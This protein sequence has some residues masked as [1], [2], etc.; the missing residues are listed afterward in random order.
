MKL[1]KIDEK[2][3]CIPPLISTR[4]QFIHAIYMKGNNLVI[5]LL[6][7][8]TIQIPNL[9]PDVIDKIFHYYTLYLEKEP[10]VA[11]PQDKTKEI[12]FLQA[13]EGGEGNP[14]RFSINGID[15]MMGSAMMHN[16]EQANAPDLP[17]EILDKIA[18]ITKILSPNSSEHLPKPEPHCNCMYCQITKTILKSYG[19]EPQEEKTTR[20][21]ENVSQEDL[22]FEQWDVKQT[23]DQLFKV[24]NRLDDKEHYN[25]YLGS[26]VGC[27]CGKANCEHIIAVLKS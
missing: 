15:G 22:K 16:P 3:L 25:V 7:Y 13:L 27:T 12:H 26:P 10:Q 19:E 17:S 6:D 9:V 5:T 18:A 24:S 11:P 23:G 21:I 4:W 2:I 20:A 14:F 1:M 8:D